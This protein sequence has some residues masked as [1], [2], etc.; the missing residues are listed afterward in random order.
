MRIETENDSLFDLIIELFVKIME[1][2]NLIE[3]TNGL[4]EL[5]QLIAIISY[6]AELLSEAIQIIIN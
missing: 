4:T 6:S 1:L 5:L 2:I 3:S